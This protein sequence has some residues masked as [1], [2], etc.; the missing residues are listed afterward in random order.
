[1][2]IFFTWFYTGVTFKPDEMAEN[3]HKSSGF[4][5]GIRPGE[6]TAKY[7]GGVLD[8][9][10]MLGGIFA[11]IIAISP[12][13]INNYTTFKGIQFGGTSLLIIVG[14]A[15]EAVRVLESQLIMRHYQ[16]FLK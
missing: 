13:I 5:P 9:V 12:M 7:I 2:V 15:V 10:S 14:V 11:G 8:R 16:G 4:I 1:M 3:M 6:P